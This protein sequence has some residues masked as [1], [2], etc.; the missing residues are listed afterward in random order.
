MIKKYELEKTACY[1]IGDSLSDVVAGLNAGIR[2]VGP[3]AGEGDG[4]FHG[5]DAE[6]FG[7]VVAWAFE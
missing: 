4:L 5:T 6:A 2:S 7:S 1:K 3:H